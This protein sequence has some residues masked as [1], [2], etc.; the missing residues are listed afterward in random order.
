MLPAVLAA[1]LLAPATAGTS[2]SGAFPDVLIDDRGRPAERKALDAALERLKR[3]PTARR[4]ARRHGRLAPV[5]LSFA[6]ISGST[7]TV[8]EDTTL[9]RSLWEQDP[10]AVLIDDRLAVSTRPITDILAHELY[11][12][13]LVLRAAQRSGGGV[14]RLMENEAWSLA[15]GYVVALE[16]GDPV[17]ADDAAD[18]IAESTGAYYSQ[19][20]FSDSPERIELSLSEAR[21]PRAAIAAR[22][23]ELARRRRWVEVR[24]KDL[25]VWD[26]RLSH[27]EK[28]HGL[29]ARS[30]REL[31]DSLDALANTLIP[32]RA[33]LL[34]A[35]EPHLRSVQKWLDEPE[36]RAWQAQMAAVAADP[37]ARG[38]EAEWAAL[39]RRLARLKA[40][41]AKAPE[42][43]TSAPRGV[44]QLGWEEVT[45]LVDK[46]KAA[47]PGHWQG[48]PETEAP[49]E[50]IVP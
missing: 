41:Q 4:L 29:D 13:D 32:K 10:P 39:G 23:K 30:V 46:D 28:V 25:A 34:D 45:V 43:P 26:F 42:P 6:P 37:Y 33:A 2:P 1:L 38:L 15:V 44:K 48:A 21:A 14:A 24:K 22:L 12:H 27:M 16:A 50:W 19:H 49:V 36:G 35:A 5:V 47:H 31:Q 11:G 3:S 9:G 8:L 18:W 20:L 17:F 40:R 7:G